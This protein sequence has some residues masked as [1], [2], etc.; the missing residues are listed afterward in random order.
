MCVD[1]GCSTG[2]NHE[3]HHTHEHSH[4]NEDIKNNPQLSHKVTVIEKILSKNNQMADEIREEFNKH[5]ITCFN[6]MSSPGSG[7]TTTL[8]NLAEKA[9]FKFGVIE[10]DLETSRDAERIRNKGIWSFQLQTGRACHLDA[11]MVKHAIPSFPFDE[12]EVAFIENVGN[13]VCPASYD[14]GAHYNMVFVSVP[15]GDDKIEKYPVMFQKADIVIITKA[16][17]LEFFDFDVQKAKESADKLKPNVPVVLLNNKTKEGLDEIIEWMK[18]KR[19]EHL[20]G[21]E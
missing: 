12:L 5:K 2:H 15:E 17:M 6:M 14:V 1:C 13:L 19:E 16:D 3:H 20:K 8:E 21:L 18:S 7:K 4:I 9:P 10:G 11:G